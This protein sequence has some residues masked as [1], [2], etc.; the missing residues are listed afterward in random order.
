M[1]KYSVGFN[2]NTTRE[3]ASPQIGNYR[4]GFDTNTTREP[5]S[6]QIGNYRVGFDTNTTREPTSPLMGKYRVGFD[7]NT[8]REPASSLMG[9]YRG[10]SDTNT[11]REPA[12]PPMG[13]YR[14]GSD[15]NTPRDP[16]SLTMGKYRVGFDTNTPRDPA[17]LTTGKYSMGFDNNI[18]RDPVSPLSSFKHMS[19]LDR[20]ESPPRGPPQ[21]P[22]KAAPTSSC[23]FPDHVYLHAAAIFRNAHAEKPA[24][25]RLISYG[26]KSDF[27]IPRVKDELSECSAYELAFNTLKYQDLLED[28]MIDSCLYLSQS[29]PDDLMSLVLVMLFDFQDRKFLPREGLAGAADEQLE[30]VRKAES[31]LFRFRTKLAAS[32]ARCR[33]KHNVPSI[34]CMLSESVKRMQERARSLPLCAWVNTLKISLD[35]ARG[36]L[37]RAG[38][39]LAESLG[40][41]SGSTFC[42]DGHCCDSLVFPGHLKDALYRTTPLLKDRQLVIQDRSCCLAPNMVRFF[43]EK[44][45]DVLVAGAVSG[46]TVAHMAAL[47]A[48]FSGLVFCCL[49]SLP[50][51]QGDE[52]QD[53]FFGM[54]C[55]NVKLIPG[56]FCDLSPSDARLQKVRVILLMPQSSL[57][58]TSNPAEIILQ[59][60][61][62]GHLL[63]DVSQGAVSQTKLD[64]L[65]GRQTQQL[66]HALKFPRVRTVVYWTCSSYPEE[67][68]E[69]VRKVL[70]EQPCSAT[71][72]PYRLTPPPMSTLSSSDEDNAEERFFKL[73]ASEETNG[74]FMAVLTREP[75][76]EVRETVQE[77]LARA[78]A[79]GLLGGVSAS[80]LPQKE[81]C[82]FPRDTAVTRRPRRSHGPIH[83]QTCIEEFLS[84]EA[85]TNRTP[86]V[87]LQGSSG[88]PGK[89]K[90][91]C[92]SLP[93]T[94]PSRGSSS[95]QWK[96]ITAIATPG[97]KR[98]PTAS[99][100]PTPRAPPVPRPR[101]RQEVLRP[102]ALVLP[103]VTFPS[104]SMKPRKP[105]P[106]SHPR[107]FFS[108][109]AGAHPAASR[110]AD[111]LYGLSAVWHPRPWL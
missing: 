20:M 91:P 90:P 60:N 47:A 48:P 94:L 77:V 111:N 61:G 45:A 46:F 72:Q 81:R 85:K 36:A 11:T 79:N 50:P 23:G 68:E 92:R 104:F 4:V 25:H 101:A 87:K 34:E 105:P 22:L 53:I 71:L 32:L 39:S 1:G 12:S 59:E 38:F 70:K 102:V 108:W 57:S 35:D 103:P 24:S 84:R 14:V 15:T 58:A 54:E 88:E 106:Y 2:T 96:N 93:G 64:S 29:L 5:T 10:G 8:T 65:V 66:A 31:C 80:Q 52:M 30:D 83:S 27:P 89:P 109:R 6:P 99:S 107:T 37:Q 75:T 51:A 73:D 97:S 100:Q 74:C 63:Q 43:L 13:K 55:K 78:A 21:L 76:L 95:Q 98:K 41:L 42:Q 49:E 44:G 33:I 56:R 62:D 9:K 110:S 67:N 19:L 17:S 82:V 26:K 18:L 40:Q 28:M 3:P 16:A 86:S 69:V 7:T